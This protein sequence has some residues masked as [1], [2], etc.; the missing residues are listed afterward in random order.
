[1]ADDSV[2]LGQT[3]RVSFKKCYAEGLNG[4]KVKSDQLHC[5]ADASERA[6]G[7]VV[8]TRAENEARVKCQVVSSK[9]ELHR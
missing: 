5:F 1:M 8:Y 2:G 4:D 6:Y 3:G 9:T 7:A